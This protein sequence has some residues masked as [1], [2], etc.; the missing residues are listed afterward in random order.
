MYHAE[1]SSLAVRR[2]VQTPREAEEL[3]Q[4]TARC[5]QLVEQIRK[6]CITV[7]FLKHSMQHLRSCRCKRPGERRPGHLPRPV[8]CR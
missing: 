4:L 6:V 7:C 8:R 5:E 1:R 2:P 3:R